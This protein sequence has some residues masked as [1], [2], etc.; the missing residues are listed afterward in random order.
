MSVIFGVFAQAL[1]WGHAARW[2][3]LA[4]AAVMFVIGLVVSEVVFGWATDADLQPNI[5]GLSFDE[6]LLTFLVGGVV[7]LVARAF[8]WRR[9][10]R[11]QAV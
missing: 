3:W 11:P 1:F 9:G 6:V 10:H 7:V 8:V 4:A 5:D 2:L